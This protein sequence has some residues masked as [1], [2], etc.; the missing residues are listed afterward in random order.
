MDL[1]YDLVL[2]ED[3]GRCLCSQKHVPLPKVWARVQIGE[4]F[5]ILCP[6]SAMNLRALLAE[7]T[8]TGGE[9]SGRVTKHYGKYIRDLAAEIFKERNGD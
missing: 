5:I 4:E 8:L 6:T 2:L 1:K 3:E 7:W 9:P